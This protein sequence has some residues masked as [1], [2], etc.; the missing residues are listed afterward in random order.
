MINLTGQP[1]RFYT[2]YGVTSFRTGEW[3][4]GIL[5]VEDVSIRLTA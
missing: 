1:V 2:P 3:P 4:P 5:I